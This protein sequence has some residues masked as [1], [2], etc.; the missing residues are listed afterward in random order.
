MS[1]CT[2]CKEPA[3][4]WRRG[5]PASGF[6]TMGGPPQPS[7]WGPHLSSSSKALPIDLVKPRERI[8]SFPYVTSPNGCLSP[9]AYAGWGG[10]GVPPGEDVTHPALPPAHRRTRLLEL[11]VTHSLIAGSAPETPVSAQHLRPGPPFLPDLSTLPVPAQLTLLSHPHFPLTST[12]PSAPNPPP[13]SRILPLWALRPMKSLQAPP[14]SLRAFL[15]SSQALIPEQ[16]QGPTLQALL[17]TPLSLQSP[18]L[19]SATSGPSASPSLVAWQD[20]H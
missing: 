10:D 3:P 19:T 18:P 1:H 12:Q 8:P 5:H 7:P 2:V 16:C 14:P 9:H 11:P 15:C 4:P 20:G 17:K 6:T 13:A